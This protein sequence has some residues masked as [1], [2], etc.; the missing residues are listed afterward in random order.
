MQNEAQATCGNA[1]PIQFVFHYDIEMGWLEVPFS[2]IAVLQLK[3]QIS[4][5]SHQ[6]GTM[7][8][9]EEGLDAQL[10]IR[11]YL[12]E[13]GKPGEHQFFSRLCTHVFDGIKSNIR[14]FPKYDSRSRQ[15]LFEV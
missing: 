14:G 6:N 12:K 8:Y 5:S 15:T 11:K 2:A 13:I 10:F 3:K 1:L 4:T 7:V 9:L